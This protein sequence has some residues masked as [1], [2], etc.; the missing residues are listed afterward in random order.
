MTNATA[1]GLALLLTLAAPALLGLSS[2]P[3][4]LDPAPS[5]G[6]VTVAPGI[7]FGE[8]DGSSCDGFG[9]FP[10]GASAEAG[11]GTR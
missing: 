7:C 11:A 4:I 3:S 6:A 8:S 1:I 2:V 10:G 5:A 9:A